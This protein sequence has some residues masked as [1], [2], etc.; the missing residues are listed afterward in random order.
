MKTL[1][2]IRCEAQKLPKEQ[3]R[4]LLE[5]AKDMAASQEVKQHNPT[6]RLPTGD[7]K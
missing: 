6:T 1:D 5:T 7:R 3:L 4:E 2:S